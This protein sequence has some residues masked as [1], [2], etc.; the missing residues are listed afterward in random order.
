V[1]LHQVQQL[2]GP[3]PAHTTVLMVQTY[4]P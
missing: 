2:Y 1:W 3:I 4:M